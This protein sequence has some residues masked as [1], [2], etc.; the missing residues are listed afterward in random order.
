MPENVMLYR[1]HGKK[2]KFTVIGL[3]SAIIALSCTSALATTYPLTVENCGASETFKRPPARVV[4]VGQHETEL[5]L[6]LGLEKSIV[7]T[8]VWFGKLPPELEEE[9]AGLKRLADNSPGFEAVA[10]QRPELVLAQYSWHVGPQGAVA[11]RKHFEQLGIRT[12]TSPAA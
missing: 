3:A 8:S 5:L 9:G 12:W 2:M 10:A 11:T 4:T 6:A 7:G 1:N